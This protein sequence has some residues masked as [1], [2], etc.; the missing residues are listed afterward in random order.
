LAPTRTAENRFDRR[1]H[2]RRAS[3]TRGKKESI[4]GL[5]LRKSGGNRMGKLTWDFRDGHAVI[6][7][8]VKTDFGWDSEQRNVENSEFRAIFDLA[9]VE[10]GWI[11]FLKGVGINAKLVPAGDD[12]G[13]QPSEDHREGLRVVLKMDRELGGELREMISTWGAMWTAIDK[14]HDD[15]LAGAIKHKD[16]V[17]VVEVAGTR[18]ETTSKGDTIHIPIFKIVS[19]VQR[20]PDLPWAGIP[21]I[22]RAKKTA[23]GPGQARQPAAASPQGKADFDDFDETNPPF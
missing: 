6:E 16:Q 5:G 17:P 1:R 20:P 9:N 10:R 14:L 18:E 12:P 15:Y 3:T 13:D 19:W 7:D 2:G 22:Q 8:R 11:A 23:N 4:M 21:L